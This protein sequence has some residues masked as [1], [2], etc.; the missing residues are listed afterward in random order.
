MISYN[1]KFIVYFIS[2]QSNYVVHSI[3]E[4]Y[5]SRFEKQREDLNILFANVKLTLV[6]NN[7][8]LD[9]LKFFLSLH[10][11]LRHDAKAVQSLEDAV[12]A[13]CDRTSLINTKYIDAVARRFKLHDATDLIKTFD[14]SIDKFCKTFPTK[15]IKG[16]DFMQHSRKQLQESEK[17]EFVLEWE[18][19][20]TTLS[21][22]QCLLRKAFHD[23]A[24]HVLVKVVNERNS[25]IVI[26]YAPPQLHGDLA[27]LVKHNEV[28][29][30]NQRVISITIG[31]F[32]IL[33]RETE[34]KV[35]FLC[36]FIF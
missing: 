8:A 32:V 22:I 2:T 19:D 21:D 13:V 14:D 26:C 9:S 7:I 31:G 34:S 11:E 4:N 25:I 35:S 36:S 16:Q 24:R 15:H 18:E 20:K 23:M 5:Q 1:N 6:R 29:L 27:I 3:S 28:Y 12:M 17:V 10:W 33:Q 30:K